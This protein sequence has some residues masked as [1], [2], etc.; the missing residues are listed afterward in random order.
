[1][2]RG[3]IGGKYALNTNEK[4]ELT[5]TKQREA[6]KTID[7]VTAQLNAVA[8]RTKDWSKVVI[9]YEPVW[10][11]HPIA[12]IPQFDIVL[13]KFEGRLELGKSQLRNKPKKSICRSENGSP[14]RYRKKPR[15]QP[16]SSMVVR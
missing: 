1:M 6:N 15:M 4:L 10:L 9:A 11:A 14:R 13:T 12:P 8:D 3:D 2:R 16:G 7:V 5:H